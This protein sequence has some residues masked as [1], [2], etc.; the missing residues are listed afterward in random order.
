[1]DFTLR[2]ALL[3]LRKHDGSEN[4]E[5]AKNLNQSQLFVQQKPTRYIDFSINNPGLSF[6]MP[7][8][9]D[10][11]QRIPFG[12][13]TCLLLNEPQPSSGFSDLPPNARDRVSR[14]STPSIGK[15]IQQQK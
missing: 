13:Q 5:T 14:M 10:K 12:P 2:V 9:S 7:Q 1:M 4:G 6:R 3:K 8:I 11:F 15:S